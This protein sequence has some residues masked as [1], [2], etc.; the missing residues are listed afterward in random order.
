MRSVCWILLLLS[1]SE[2]SNFLLSVLQSATSTPDS[3]RFSAAVNQISH[4]SFVL[5][6][7]QNTMLHMLSL[8]PQFS[9]KRDLAFVFRLAWLDQRGFLLSGRILALCPSLFNDFLSTSW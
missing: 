5:F 2:T 9:D 4:S 7:T 1:V 8:I 6:R 3:S